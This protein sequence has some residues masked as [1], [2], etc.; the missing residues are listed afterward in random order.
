MAVTDCERCGHT[1]HILKECGPCDTNLKQYCL[2]A[3]GPRY[4]CQVCKD[5]APD[6]LKRM[7]KIEIETTKY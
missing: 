2:C 1:Y 7:S 5:N 6:Y 4:A 3:G